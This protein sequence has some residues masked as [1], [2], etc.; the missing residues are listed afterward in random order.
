[1]PDYATWRA[2]VMMFYRALL[3]HTITMMHY[4]VPAGGFVQRTMTNALIRVFVMRSRLI[5]PVL[6]ILCTQ[7]MAQTR[8]MPLAPLLGPRSPPCSLHASLALFLATTAE[9]WISSSFATR[10]VQ[11]LS[12]I[13][14]DQS[15]EMGL[16]QV[17]WIRKIG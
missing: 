6:H 1:M 9:L 17:R 8:R 16:V 12:L 2:P 11:S 4:A 7:V 15:S 5:A 3:V 13:D 10:L 14:E